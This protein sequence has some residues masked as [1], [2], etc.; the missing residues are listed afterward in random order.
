MSVQVF[1]NR[2]GRHWAKYFKSVSSM[3][4][5]ANGLASIGCKTVGAARSAKGFRYGAVVLRL[6]GVRSSRMR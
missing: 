5:G 2:K 1:K 6:N 4:R 3:T